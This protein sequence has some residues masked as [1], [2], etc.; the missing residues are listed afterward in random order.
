MLKPLLLPIPLALLLGAFPLVALSQ[1]YEFNRSVIGLR[2][3]A[4]TASEVQTSSSLVDFGRVAVNTTEKRQVAL[5]NTGAAAIRLT[6]VPSFGGNWAFAATGTA[7]I[8]SLG[9]GESCLNEVEFYPAVEG[10]QRIE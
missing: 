5:I 6:A 8:T 7:C 9:P 3:S 4:D 1:T 2:V 10:L